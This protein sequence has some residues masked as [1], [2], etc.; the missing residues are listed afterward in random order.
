[1]LSAGLG[2]AG[3]APR[4]P[5]DGVDGG[6]GSVGASRTFPEVS[7]FAGSDT[8]D[9]AEPRRCSAVVPAD[10]TFTYQRSSG[11]P[12]SGEVRAFAAIFKAPPI[13]GDSVQN[14]GDLVWWWSS[15]WARTSGKGHDGALR[16]SEGRGAG[17]G[18]ELDDTLAPDVGRLEKN[19]WYWF[20]AWAWDDSLRLNLATEARAFCVGG[21][22]PCSQ[23]TAS[24]DTVSDEFCL[25]TPGV[26]PRPPGS[27]WR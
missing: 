25:A 4:E 14:Q 19:H 26:P 13:V 18:G 22:C 11:S 5:S 10:A 1:M 24:G 2:C 17:P 8:L 23:T 12:G 27:C 21:N 20:A 9:V 7:L 6:A 16:Y 3:S 15:G